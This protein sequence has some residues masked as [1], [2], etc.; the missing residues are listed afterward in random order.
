MLPLDTQSE[1]EREKRVTNLHASGLFLNWRIQVEKKKKNDCW[2]K[3]LD[4]ET[5]AVGVD[6]VA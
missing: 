6:V 1:R 4:R 5:Q 2:L 3:V